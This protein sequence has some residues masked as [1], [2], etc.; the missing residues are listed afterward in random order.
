MFWASTVLIAISV[1]LFAVRGVSPEKPRKFDLVALG[2]A[3]L[4]LAWALQIIFLSGGHLTV[5]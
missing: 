3:C 5:H 4:S 2:L 1:A